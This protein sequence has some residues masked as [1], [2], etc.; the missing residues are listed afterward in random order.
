MN[1]TRDQNPA[2]I[3]FFSVEFGSCA[4][5]VFLILI[6]LLS[7]YAVGKEIALREN[8]RDSRTWMAEKTAA[9]RAGCARRHSGPENEAARKD[10]LARIPFDGDWLSASVPGPTGAAAATESPAQD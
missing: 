8:A 4:A 9:V 6:A 10:C 5:F 1:S 2:A 3:R 7:G